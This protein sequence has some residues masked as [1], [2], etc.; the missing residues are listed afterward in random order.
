MRVY[1]NC[2][3]NPEVPSIPLTNG[4]GVLSIY[5]KLYCIDYV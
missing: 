1:F 2:H 3:L 4:T 5:N